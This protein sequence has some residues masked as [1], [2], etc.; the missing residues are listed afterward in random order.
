MKTPMVLMTPFPPIIQPVALAGTAAI[1]V[2]AA[3]AFITPLLLFFFYK[4]D[5]KGEDDPM[6]RSTIIPWTA[7]LEVLVSSGIK[8]TH[9]ALLDSGCTRCLR[10]LIASSQLN[11]LITGEMSATCLTEP[12]KIK[13]GTHTETI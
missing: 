8:W 11:S 3:A 7:R 6:I 10:T 5:S 9:I 1:P 12:V 4:S 2:Q 13:A